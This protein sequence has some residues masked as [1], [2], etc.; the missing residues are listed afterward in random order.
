MLMQYT[1]YLTFRSQSRHLQWI[2][3]V[4]HALYMY[5]SLIATFLIAQSNHLL[6]AMQH[7]PPTS[8]CHNNCFNKNHLSQEII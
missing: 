1:K 2:P 4:I 6:S 8:A 5:V 7:F 3:G